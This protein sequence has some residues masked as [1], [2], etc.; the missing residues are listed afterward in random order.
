M[1]DTKKLGS[2]IIYSDY[3]DYIIVKCLKA[4]IGMS[5]S[6]K[7]M[8]HATT[9]GN[10]KLTNGMMIGINMY[11]PVAKPKAKKGTKKGYTPEK[12]TI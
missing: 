6:G 1:A 3:K 12:L 7:S 4:E 10:V 5:K 8:L 11:T 2:N 9:H